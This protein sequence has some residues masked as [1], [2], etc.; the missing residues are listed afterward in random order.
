M[1]DYD[2]VIQEDRA[3]TVEITQGLRGPKGDKGD[4]GIQGP[5]GPAGPAGAN[6]IQGVQGPPG[7]QGPQGL[8]GPTGPQG[9]QGPKGDK[10][11]AGP[12]GPA[13]PQGT[14]STVPGPQGPIGP[15][16]PQG[17]QGDPG[18]QGPKGDKGDTGDTGP[19]GPQGIQGVPGPKGDTGDVG[20]EGPQGP[21]GPQGPQGIQGPIGQSDHSL[22][23]NLSAD[24]HAQYHNDTRGDARYYQKSAVDTMLSTLVPSQT[25]NSGKYL[26]TDGTSTSWASVGGTSAS[27]QFE[28]RDDMVDYWYVNAPGAVNTPVPNGRWEI[29][30]T[31]SSQAANAGGYATA[32]GCSSIV[33]LGSGT[34]YMRS[35][36]NAFVWSSL[37]P[38]YS[39]FRYTHRIRIDSAEAGAPIRFGLI[40]DPLATTPQGLYFE[41]NQSVGT[42]QCKYYNGVNSGSY[43]TGVART[44]AFITCEIVFDAVGETATF[45]INGTNVFSTAFV[46]T[47]TQARLVTSITSP[48]STYSNVLTD[49]V[50]FVMNITR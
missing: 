33:Q 41:Y 34:T 16:G 8:T 26:T 42:Y 14:A 28:F 7:P 37:L 13:G 11:D 32:V 44:S 35:A 31:G 9:P 2:V 18:P 43:T 21:A 6:G 19:V 22:L 38:S 27:A 36:F 3:I 45:F 48:T 20:P 30:G 15:E 39:G 24:D 40:N 46:R 47:D 49:Y 5:V 12:Q 4:P 29:Y 10:G 25:G 1:A 23:T 17:P 50:Q